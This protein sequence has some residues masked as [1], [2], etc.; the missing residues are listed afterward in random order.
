MPLKDELLQELEINRDRPVSGQALARKYSVSRTA[1]WKAIK[2]L[3]AR[4]VPNRIR[5]QPRLPAGAGRR[6]PV[7]LRH[8]TAAER[9][10][11]GICARRRRFHAERG[12]APVC[13]RREKPFFHRRR[14]PDRG[15]RTPRTAVL[16]SARHRTVP[17]VRH[18]HAVSCGSRPQHYSLRR[19]VRV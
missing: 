19:R 14:F 8:R 13:R 2:E 12:K 18:A 3:K 7:S 17:D 11:A 5:Y 4:G 1:V 9:F 6:S 10:P 15:T 16:F